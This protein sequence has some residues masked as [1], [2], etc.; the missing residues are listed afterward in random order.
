VLKD[1]PPHTSVA[2]VPAQII[3][4][5]KD[6]SPALGMCQDFAV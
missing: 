5:T 4:Q 6:V 2:G 3:G 1:V